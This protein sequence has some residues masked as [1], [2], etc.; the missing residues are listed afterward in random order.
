MSLPFG[1]LFWKL[2]ATFGVATLLGIACTVLLL[3]ASGP[4]PALEQRFWLPLVPISFGLGFCL[5]AGLVAAWY[6]SRPLTHLREALRHAAEARFEVRV[7]PQLGQ[8]RD[9]IVDLAREFDRMAQRLQ[10]ASG[11]QQR[12]F[13]DVSHELRSP[14]ARMQAAI[15]LL[16]QDPSNMG[17]AT[18]RLKR[19]VQRLDALVDEL[20]TLHRLEAGA[21]EPGRERIDVID[22]LASIVE[23][24]DFEAHTRGCSVQLHST[25]RFVCEVD[26][27]LIYRAFENVIRNA[28]KYTG[29]GTCVD[30]EAQVEGGELR[31]T[32][33]DRGP[34]VAGNQ[35]EE[36]F[37]PFRR[38]YS[39]QSDPS[40]NRVPGT[41]LGLTIARRAFALHAG[42]VE[43]RLRDGGGLSV[44]CRLPASVAPEA[45]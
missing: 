22:L 23:D 36:I 25:Q 1:R 35:L 16:Q 41:G 21:A 11:R 9:E 43:A 17:Q 6:L 31:V 27:E 2:F 44:V 40:G 39:G 19:E 15:G 20:L 4:P 33:Q 28:V 37:E 10:D 29:E 12:L 24:A 26:G 34:G 32:V 3:D 38:A 13:H 14:L 5:L 45:S 18:E 8:R 7:L 42:K 30:V